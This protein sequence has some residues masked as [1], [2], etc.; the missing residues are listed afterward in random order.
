MT[1]C[2]V[3]FLLFLIVCL[4]I[5]H[6][7]PPSMSKTKWL[8]PRLARHHAVHDAQVYDYNNAVDGNDNDQNDSNGFAT[9]LFRS[10]KFCCAPP[11]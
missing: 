9:W 10:R 5:I 1:S 6:A 11:L 7:Y 2:F 8:S 4:A 3:R